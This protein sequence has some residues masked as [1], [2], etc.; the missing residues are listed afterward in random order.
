MI[1]YVEMNKVADELQSIIYGW[2]VMDKFNKDQENYFK[3]KEEIDG[4]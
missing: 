2:V 1:D 4:K 3:L